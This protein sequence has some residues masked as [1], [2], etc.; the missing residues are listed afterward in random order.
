MGVRHEV[1]LDFFVRGFLPRSRREWISLC[2]VV[3]G[4]VRDRFLSRECWIVGKYH[5]A[6]KLTLHPRDHPL[7]L[8]TFNCRRNVE[9]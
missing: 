9:F 8:L 6:Q 3:R 5:V 2:N 4:S 1:Y 7:L